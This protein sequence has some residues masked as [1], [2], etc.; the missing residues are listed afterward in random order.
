MSTLKIYNGNTAG[1]ASNREELRSGTTSR[2]PRES[3]PEKQIATEIHGLDSVTRCRE[4]RG[5]RVKVVLTGYDMEL[6]VS[7]DTECILSPT[8]TAASRF[9]EDH[10]GCIGCSFFQNEADTCTR[11]Y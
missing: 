3:M 6:S 5:G 9:D 11:P 7:A 2:S 1:K 10:A 8:D 4:T